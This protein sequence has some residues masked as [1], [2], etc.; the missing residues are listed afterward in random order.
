MSSYV[1][2]M[3]SSIPQGTVLGPL[4]FLIFI[5]DLTR[6]ISIS[7]IHLF[8]FADDCLVCHTI[9]SPK[10]SIQLEGAPDHV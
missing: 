5:S 4:P 8:M 1:V 7:S 9:H 10:G 2:P 6:S 3:I